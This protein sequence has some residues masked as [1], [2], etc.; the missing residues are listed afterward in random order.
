MAGPAAVSMVAQRLLPGSAL[1]LGLSLLTAAFSLG[2]SLGPLLAG[3]VSDA[4]GSL[5]AG[6]WLG[7]LLLCAAAAV[8]T[9]QNT[10]SR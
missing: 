5:A 6:L 7:P 1:T 2:Q 8:S 4:T 10:A 3:A 9:R